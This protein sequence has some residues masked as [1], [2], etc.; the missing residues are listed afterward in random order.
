MRRGYPKGSVVIQV[1]LWSFA[2]FLSAADR[3][4]PRPSNS[5][6][7]CFDLGY[8]GDDF[9]CL[10]NVESIQHNSLSPLVHL[11][12]ANDHYRRFYWNL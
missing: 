4:L 12:A 3:E 8:S 6:F 5:V 11:R 10:R 7:L 9:A 1:S 2:V